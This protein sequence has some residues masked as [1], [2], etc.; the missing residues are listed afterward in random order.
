MKKALLF[1]VAFVAFGLTASAQ[2]FTWKANVAINAG[3]CVAFQGNFLVPCNNIASSP[4]AV[5]GV[6]LNTVTAQPR[7]QHSTVTVQQSGLA[8][9]PNTAFPN[10]LQEGDYIGDVDGTGNLNDLG[11]PLGQFIIGSTGIGPLNNNPFGYAGIYVEGT[12]TTITILVQP[13]IVPMVVFP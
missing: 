6:A 3:Q 5:A 4:Y 10:V 8:T 7:G 11:F 9:I 2:T 12:A 13:G 1:L